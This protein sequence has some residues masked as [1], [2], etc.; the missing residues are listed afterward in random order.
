MSTIM[1]REVS[2]IEK[3][4]AEGK[5]Y[6]EVMTPKMVSRYMQKKYNI[7][8]KL[9]ELLVKA[10]GLEITYENKQKLIGDPFTFS[11][12]T[13]GAVNVMIQRLSPY[14]GRA[15]CPRRRKLEIRSG[16]EIAAP[17]FRSS[18]RVLFPFEKRHGR[19][20]HRSR[21]SHQHGN[22]MVSLLFPYPPLH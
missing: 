22:D 13:Q 4:F 2:R 21:Q 11:G 3:A 16:P 1:E 9:I 14:E 15:I 7:S 18:A 17:A 6:E 20:P 5:S 10:K 12:E 8:D 19:H